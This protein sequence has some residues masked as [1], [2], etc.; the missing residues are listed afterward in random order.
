MSEVDDLMVDIMMRGDTEA[1]LAAVRLIRMA[2]EGQLN[3]QEQKL[4]MKAIE[5]R[6]VNVKTGSDLYDFLM[7]LSAFIGGDE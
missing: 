4:V 5:R 1:E 7:R 6:M 3:A 2:E